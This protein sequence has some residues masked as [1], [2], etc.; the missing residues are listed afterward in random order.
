LR[1]RAAPRLAPLAA[2]PLTS[3]SLAIEGA[4]LRGIARALVALAAPVVRRLAVATLAAFW[5]AAALAHHHG[6]E[7][8]RFH[9]YGIEQGLSHSTARTLAQDKTGY[10]WIGTQDGLNRFDGNEFRVFRHDPTDSGGI[11]DNYVMVVAPDGP[12]LWVGSQAGGLHYYDALTGRFTRYAARP[13]VAGALASNPVTA[14]RRDSRGRLWVGSGAGRLQWLDAASGVFTD[15]PVARQIAFGIVRIVRERRNGDFLIGGRGGLWIVNANGEPK[16]ELRWQTGAPLDVYDVVESAHGDLWAGTAAAGLYRFDPDGTPKVRL[17]VED[18]LTDNDIRALLVDREHR[19][20]VGTYDGL[21]RI[22]EPDRPAATLHTW[23]YNP[24]QADGLASNRVQSLLEDRDGLVWIGTWLNGISVFN[25]RTEAFV[26]IRPEPGDPRAIPGNP[27]PGLHIDADGTFWLGVLEGG[28]L[29]HFDLERGVLARY[30]HDPDDPRSLSH[31]YVQNMTRGS[32]GALWVATAGG[33][34]NRMLPDGS[35]FER[36]RHDPADPDS[37]ASDSIF[38]LSVDR[39]GTLW[40]GTLEGGLDARCATCTAF[41]HYRHDPDDPTTLPGPDVNTIYESARGD[42]WVGVRAGGLARLDRATGRFQRFRADPSVPGSLSND[43]VTVIMEDRA[44]TLWVGTQ[45]GGLNRL[46]VGE[47]AEDTRFRAYTR[48]NGLAADAIGGVIEDEAGKLWVSTTMGV[49][50]LDPATGAIENFGQRDGV[51]AH[52]Y[53]IG[54]YGR[55]PDGGIA[56]GGLRGVTL[57]DPR[58]IE[59]TAIV[60]AVALTAFRTFRST[61]RWNEPAFVAR[62]DAT[63]QLHYDLRHDA[64]EFSVEFSAL[65]FADPQALHYSYQLE[66][67]DATWIRTDARRRFAGYTNLKP[68]DYTLRLRARHGGAPYGPETRVGIHLSASPW[69][70]AWA[71][72]GYVLAGLSVLGLFAWQARTRIVERRVAA[73]RQAE[74]EERL[75]LALWGTGD[76]LWDSDLRTGKLVRLNPLQHL[77]VNRDAPDVSLTAYAPFVHPDDLA[78]MNKA[79]VEHAQGKTDYFEATYR[80]RDLAG[81]WRWMR[82][83]GR[84]VKRDAKGMA[85]RMVGT[86]E[87]ITDIKEHEQT[88][89]RINQDLERRVRDRTADLTTANESL[90]NTIEQLRQA[91]RQLVESEKMAALG[92]LVAGIAHEINTPLGI[93]VTAASHL[94]AEAA[95]IS[96]L[97]ETNELKKSDLEAFQRIAAESTQLILRNLQR[98]DKLVKSFKQVAVDQSSEQRR[99]IDLKS[100]LDEILTSLHPALKKTPHKVTVDCPETLVLDTYPGAVYQIVVN[101]VMN[102]LIHAFE[103]TP[104]GHITIVARRDLEHVELTYADDGRG[105][106]EAVRTRIFEPFFTT[107]RGQGGS[108]LGMHIVYNLATQVLRGTIRCESEPGKGVKFTIRFPSDVGRVGEAV[109]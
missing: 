30:V 96:R 80:T 78:P 68:G 16:R 17:R 19:L 74:S 12:N 99:T 103:G 9:H 51:Q 85:L 27:V 18:G 2:K 39:A 55:H 33:G 89:E 83:R 42:L 8:V 84:V 38:R 90:R 6:V 14:L 32:D 28:G 94:G 60:S 77:Q 97:L 37:V 45:G 23:K 106:S 11:G 93:G 53:F 70:S 64:D 71:R 29:V 54:A 59:P 108:G 41:T 73:R 62:V 20:W 5:S 107:R 15:V 65:H 95:R 105:M 35:G 69:R 52:G 88:L 104:P 25:P 34:L 63:G 36:F 48:R 26:A 98:A 22:D 46:V 72:A 44:G 102:S 3:E 40:V 4:T 56:F 100:Y 31:N 10:V 43:S 109:A 86:T 21:V 61:S 82:S 81:N 13:G 66:G 57:F 87:D 67:F 47:R 7:R 92:N 24:S 50:R 49:S 1:G 75:K 101:L 91:Q 58:A 76:E 79:M